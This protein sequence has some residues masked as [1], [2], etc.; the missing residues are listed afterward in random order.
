MDKNAI[1]VMNRLSLNH[2]APYLFHNPILFI[3]ATPTMNE[4]K[5]G[6]SLGK[7]TY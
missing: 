4:G 1:T 5:R 6:N 3:S 2:P 7:N